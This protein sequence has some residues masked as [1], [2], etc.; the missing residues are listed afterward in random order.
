MLC[1]KKHSRN[2]STMDRKAKTADSRIMVR[3]SWVPTV[4]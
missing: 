4:F 1:A 3:R 2:S